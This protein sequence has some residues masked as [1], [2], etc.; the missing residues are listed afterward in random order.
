VNKKIKVVELIS[1]A[2]PVEPIPKE[3]FS[4]SPSM[5]G[6]D[7][8]DSLAEELQGKNWKLVLLNNWLYIAYPSTIM[9]MIT[10]TAFHYYLPSLLIGT[11]EDS[12]YFDWGA[13]ALLPFNK[14][15]VRKGA[16]WFE[17]ESLF[18]QAQIYAVIAFLE[19]IETSANELDE[20][21]YLAKDAILLWKTN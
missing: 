15:H 4:D 17:Y 3:F 11:I 14:L 9:G 19:Y 16:W 8:D 20:S 6:G 18:N 13:S 21:K 2:F 1:K 5:R 10:P 7:I 12:G